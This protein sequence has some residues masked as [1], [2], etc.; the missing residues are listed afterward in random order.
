MLL[1]DST[2][3]R[4][5]TPEHLAKQ[6]MIYPFIDKQVRANENG[7]KVISYGLTSFGYDVRLKNEVKLFTNLNNSIVDP[8]DVKDDCFVTAKINEDKETGHKY[9]ILPPNSY[10]LG[11]TV[12]TFNMPSDVT[13][14]CVGKSTW[15][16]C[17]LL[18]NVTPIEAGFVG[19]V[20]IELANATSLPIKVYTGMG[21]A[22]FLF[23]RGDDECDTSYADRDGK[24]MNQKNLQLALA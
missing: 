18:V 21:I 19:E 11:C 4:L 9:F 3:T 17:G 8:M 2:I 22:Q 12:E 5:A 23:H 20:V 13:A 15:A 7:C 24:Y 10:A 16:R 14:I 6:P 1:C